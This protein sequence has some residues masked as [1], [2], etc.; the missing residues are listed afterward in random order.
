MQMCSDAEE[1]GTERTPSA[2]R[3][4]RILQEGRKVGKAAFP[5]SAGGPPAP[6]CTDE[7]LVRG[8][9][10]MEPH[11]SPQNPSR[12]T[13]KTIQIVDCDRFNDAQKKR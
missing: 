3:K 7:M 13:G 11:E 8:D 1:N 6:R 4:R 5:G 12:G 10:S 2:Q 9:I